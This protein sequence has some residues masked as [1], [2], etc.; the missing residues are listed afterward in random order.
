MIALNQKCNIYRSRMVKNQYKHTEKIWY[1]IGTDVPCNIQAEV[2]VT[3]SNI[4]QESTGVTVQNN[5]IGFFYKG[6]KIKSGDKVLW[7]GIELFVKI[8]N[9]VFAG[10]N[11]IHH[12]EALLGLEET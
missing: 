2:R 9:P 3:G 5:Y 1:I 6:A 8:A 4:N 7:C 11:S 12:I 10:A